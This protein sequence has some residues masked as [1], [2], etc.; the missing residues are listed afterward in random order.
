MKHLESNGSKPHWIRGMSG[1]L[2]PAELKSYKLPKNKSPVTDTE[3]DRIVARFKLH[4]VK[5]QVRVSR[6]GKGGQKSPGWVMVRRR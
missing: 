6:V 2:P 1:N 4:F 5:I 3:T